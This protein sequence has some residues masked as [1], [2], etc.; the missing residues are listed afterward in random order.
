MVQSVYKRIYHG[1][2]TTSVTSETAIPVATINVGSEAYTSTKLVYVKVRDKAGKRN[3]YLTGTDTIFSNPYQA[4]GVTTLLNNTSARL[5][6]FYNDD[7]FTM[8]W[9]R[10][11]LFAS[12]LNAKGEL[13][14]FG[15]YADTRT[16]TIDGT[17]TIDVYLLDYPDNDS[18]FN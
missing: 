9:D 5:C 10:Y 8:I 1:E 2:I 3:G 15:R 11:G 16:K 17:Y 4:N 18:M 7:K 6:V 12:S 13:K 14:I